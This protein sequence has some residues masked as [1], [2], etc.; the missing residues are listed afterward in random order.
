MNPPPSHRT[1]LRSPGQ[2]TDRTS[3]ARPKAAT[4]SPMSSL[5]SRS[6]TAGNTTCH[7][8][9]VPVRQAENRSNSRA[10]NGGANAASW[11]SNDTAAATGQ[12]TA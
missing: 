11:K 7:Q 6:P 5:T 8:R 10:I 4:N 12:D 1:C 3:T 9:P 2:R